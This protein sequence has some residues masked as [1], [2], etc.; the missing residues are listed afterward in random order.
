VAL[1]RNAMSKEM[2]ATLG[3][4]DCRAGFFQHHRI[5]CMA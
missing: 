4:R 3:L 1:Q 2:K 5:Y